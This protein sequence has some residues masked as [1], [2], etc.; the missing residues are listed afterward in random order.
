MPWSITKGCLLIQNQQYISLSTNLIKYA[1]YGVEET[2][3]FSQGIKLQTVK[4]LN[5]HVLTKERM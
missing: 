1:F 5:T 2:E 4:A 3:I